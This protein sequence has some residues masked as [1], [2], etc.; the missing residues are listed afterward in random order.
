[1]MRLALG[2]RGSFF[3]GQCENRA[4]ADEMRRA[5]VLVEIRKY[6]RERLCGA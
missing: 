4:L 3:R 5:V 2:L 1:M 6:R